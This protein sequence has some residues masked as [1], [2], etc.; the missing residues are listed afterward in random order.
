MKISVIIGLAMLCTAF[1]ASCEHA[2]K[3]HDHNTATIQTV[4]NPAPKL[5]DLL[6]TELESW[7]GGEVI[8][9]TV[10]APPNTNLPIH[11]HNGEEFIY[12]LEGSAVVWQK[13]KPEIVLNAGDVFKIPYKQ[14]HTAI[15]R[16]SS[17][18]AIVFRVHEKGKPVRVPVD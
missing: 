6:R 13:D 7:D 8:V 18:K 16:E 9:S 5:T 17:V 2:E 14:V 12:V 3:A 11:Y 10:E 1:F 15:T 4:D